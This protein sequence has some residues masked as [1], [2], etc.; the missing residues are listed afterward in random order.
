MPSEQVRKRLENQEAILRFLRRSGGTTRT[1][2]SG[3]CRIRRS[4]VTNICKDLID[5]GAVAEVEPGY[6]R[7]A[8]RLEPSFWGAVAVLS[9]IHI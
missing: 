5:A 7:S 9:L 3:G 2:L 8:V 6:Y 1:A 4:S